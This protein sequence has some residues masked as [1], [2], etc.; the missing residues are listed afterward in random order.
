MTTSG[1]GMNITKLIA[2]VS[3]A[4]TVLTMM[5]S[6]QLPVYAS[7]TTEDDGLV[8]DDEDSHGEI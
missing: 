8:E 3:L 1:Q 4:V 2:T 6:N 5:T 7:P